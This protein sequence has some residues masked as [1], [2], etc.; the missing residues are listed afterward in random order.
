MNRWVNGLP[1]GQNAD[2]FRLY[3]KSV[4]I[5]DPQ[6]SNLWLLVDE[7]PNSINDGR[8]ATNPGSYIPPDGSRNSRTP[9]WVDVPAFYHNRA[10]GFAFADGHSEIKQW[11]DPRTYA[12]YPPGSYG[13]FRFRTD[14][15]N[16]DLMW[17]LER[18]TALK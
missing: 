17:L 2:E 12:D 6:P 15:G 7:R 9:E 16:I 3:K 8:F 13:Q 4:E 11:K 18:S 1:F 5:T 14:P 10:A